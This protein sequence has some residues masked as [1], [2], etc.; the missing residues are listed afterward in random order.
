VKMK[1]VYSYHC[2]AV[3]A[4]FLARAGAAESSGHSEFVINLS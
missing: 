4:L 2:T 1:L 3:A